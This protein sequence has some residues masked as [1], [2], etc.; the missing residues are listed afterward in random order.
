[1]E[2]NDHPLIKEAKSMCKRHLL[3]RPD[4]PLLKPE[5]MATVAELRGF[6]AA[7]LN[8]CL[9]KPLKRWSR[10]SAELSRQQRCSSAC[11]LVELQPVTKSWSFAACFDKPPPPYF[12]FLFSSSIGP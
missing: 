2:N 9:S 1:M 12:P 3:Q 5:E 8:V 10:Q 7:A 4:Q 6:A 11:N